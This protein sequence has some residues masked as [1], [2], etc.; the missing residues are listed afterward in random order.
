MILTLSFFRTKIH[1]NSLLTFGSF[2][3]YFYRSQCVFLNAG[4]TESLFPFS[5]II[6]QFQSLL[7][8]QERKRSDRYHTLLFS[9]IYVLSFF[10]LKFSFKNCHCLKQNSD[11]QISFFFLISLALSFNSEKNIYIFARSFVSFSRLYFYGCSHPRI[12][13]QT[14]DLQLDWFFFYS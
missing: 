2:V 4:L 6:S 13:N 10:F 7:I 1:V 12:S 5:F 8:R 14:F 11:M 9:Q 3:L